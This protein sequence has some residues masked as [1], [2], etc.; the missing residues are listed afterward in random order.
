MIEKGSREAI[1]GGALFEDLVFEGLDLTGLD[2]AGKTFSGC[3]FRNAKLGESRWRGARIEDC[4]GSDR[5]D[6]PGH[7][8][9][10][11]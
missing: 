3:T 10:G 7:D 8:A 6:L 9:E 4:D 5:R 2:F 11:R 1:E